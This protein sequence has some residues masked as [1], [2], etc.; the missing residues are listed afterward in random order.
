MAAGGT[1]ANVDLGPGRLYYAPLGTAEPAS[2]SAV[3]PSAWQV[4]GYTE[5]GTQISTDITSEAIEVAEELDPIRYIQTRR[6]TQLT[7]S[8]AETMVSRLALAVGAGAGRAD[9]ATAFEL[10]APDSI[11]PVMFVWDRDEVPS[12][13]NR[14]WIFRSCVPSGTIELA[15]RKAPQKRLIGVTFDCALVDGSTSPVK[16]FPNATGQI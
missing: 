5:D 2:G 4:V 7:L 14:R 13:T 10:P 6:T 16:V 15:N 3:L 12:A 11:V 1:K 8:M 9:T